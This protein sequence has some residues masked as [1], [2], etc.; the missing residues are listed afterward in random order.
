MVCSVVIVSYQV[1]RAR[2][3][4]PNALNAQLF[5]SQVGAHS[6]SKINWGFF[7]WVF[8]S[9]TACQVVTRLFFIAAKL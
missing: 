3:A 2:E 7:R 6:L 8:F 5:N 9:E 1:P 4:W